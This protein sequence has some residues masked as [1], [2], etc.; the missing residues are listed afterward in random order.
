MA[1]AAKLAR[2]DAEVWLLYGDGSS[3]YSLAEIDTCVR[4]GLPIIAVIGNDAAWMQILREQLPML[5]DGV[6]CNLKPGTR[7]DIVGKGYGGE[8]ILVTKPSEVKDAL[9]KA[10]SLA[11]SGIPVVVNCLI[12][13]SK[14][15]EGSISI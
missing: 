2:P 5:G 8:G 9:L 12:T 7:Y 15:R 6:A 10:K 14:F 3:A 11:K 4:H 13:K 1:V